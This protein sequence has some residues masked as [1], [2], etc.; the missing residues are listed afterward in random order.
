MDDEKLLQHLGVTPNYKG[1]YYLLAALE[2]LRS[3]PDSLS[4]VTKW[5]YPDIAKKYQT[6]WKSVERNLRTTVRLAWDNNPIFL[7]ALAGFPLKGRPTVTV[8]LAI[9]LKAS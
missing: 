3:H 4:L 8:F 5:L 9:L 1:F 6:S 7:Q 2:I